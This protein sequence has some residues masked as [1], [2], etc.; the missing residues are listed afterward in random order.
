MKYK[1]LMLG[2][3]GVS[4]ALLAACNDNNNNNPVVSAS[5]SIQS[6]DTAQVLALA[7]ETSETA[8]PIAVNGSAVYLNDTTETALP[9]AANAM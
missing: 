7:R 8:A 9:I 2:V 4:A 6:L 5:P 1:I 3:V